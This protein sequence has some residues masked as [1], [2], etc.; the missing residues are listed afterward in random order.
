[1]NG[2]NNNK[3]S[4]WLPKHI[5][6]MD[7]CATLS[8]PDTKNSTIYQR[9]IEEATV[10]TLKTD[11]QLDINRG[12]KDW[13][14]FTGVLFDEWTETEDSKYINI[15]DKLPDKRIFSVLDMDAI[16]AGYGNYHRMCVKEYY[17][18]LLFDIL[19]YIK[20]GKNL[21]QKVE[22]TIIDKKTYIQ[23]ITHSFTKPFIHPSVRPSSLPHR[24]IAK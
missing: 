3:T 15:P 13:E 12:K 1:M 19:N 7:I 23:E 8:I 6:K 22:R 18:L 11:V 4:Q 5:K 17:V 21:A 16:L 24:Q 14:K 9:S 2:Q 10:K 20:K